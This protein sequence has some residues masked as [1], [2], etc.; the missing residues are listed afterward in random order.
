ML[1]EQ[2]GK[3]ID[4]IITTNGKVRFNLLPPGKYLI[5]AIVDANQNLKWDTGNYLLKQKPEKVIYHS[6]IFNIRANWDF[7]IESITIK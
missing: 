4:T 1:N 5:R 7:P 3:I 2:D 6:T